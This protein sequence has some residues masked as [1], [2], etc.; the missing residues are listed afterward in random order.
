MNLISI[1]GFSGSAP[2]A[3]APPPPPPPPAEPP[4]KTNAAVQQ[5][6]G[7]EKQR[8][9]LRAGQGG[10]VKTPVTGVGDA[11]TTKTLLGQ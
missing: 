10:T 11:I 3:P 6:R 7:D 9:R 5:A 1:P 2:S 4:K 8:A